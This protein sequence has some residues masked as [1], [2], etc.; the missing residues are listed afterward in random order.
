MFILNVFAMNIKKPNQ[1]QCSLKNKT[2]HNMHNY[3]IIPIEL[4]SLS[5]TIARNCK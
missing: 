2:K 3:Q 4:L 5:I 1:I